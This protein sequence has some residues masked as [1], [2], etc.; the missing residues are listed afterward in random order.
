MTA[1]TWEGE[2]QNRADSSTQ[3]D[4]ML[5]GHAYTDSL[6]TGKAV[7]CGLI[8]T[9]RGLLHRSLLSPEVRELCSRLAA[10]CAHS[11]IDKRESD[12]QF[13]F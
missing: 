1:G 10:V 11:L 12:V 4:G 6:F 8:N 9:C 13:S 2:I 3:D 7:T 5:E